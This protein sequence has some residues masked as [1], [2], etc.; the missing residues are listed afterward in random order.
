[1]KLFL[2]IFLAVLLANLSSSAITTLWMTYT[3]R[4]A[5]EE[6][7]RELEKQRQ[8]AAEI[9]RRFEEEQATRQDALRK[10]QD[11]QRK[12]A[13]QEASVNKRNQEVCEFWKK[14]YHQRDAWYHL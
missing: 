6:A 3:A 7:T 5:L 13:E 14:Q 11:A 4:M 8:G 9:S 10:Q 12:Q 1:M 2:I